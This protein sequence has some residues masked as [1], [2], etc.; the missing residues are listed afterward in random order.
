MKNKI[1]NIETFVDS[2]SFY[3]SANNNPETI[4]NNFVIRKH[5][6]EIIIQSLKAKKNKD[7]LQHEL[8]LGRRGA[9]KS[10]L[11]KRLEIEINEN[12]KNKYVA[13]NLAEEQAGIYQLSDLWYETLQELQNVLKI[14]IELKAFSSF[15]NNNEYTRY[16]FSILNKLLLKNNKKVVLLLDN[17]DRIL[18][19]LKD[20][21]N[22]FRE[23]LLNFNNIQIIGGS[24]RMDE[25]FWTYD[26]PFYE[27]FRTYKLEPLS[28]N[29]INELFNLWSKV[30]ELPLLK[31]YALKNR[32]KIESIRI[33]TD[34]LP[35]TLQFFIKILLSNEDTYG[36]EYI[37]KIMD[38]AT[39]L[40]QERLNNLT[41][42][43]RKIILEMAFLWRP[44]ATKELV[45]SCRMEAKLISAYLK[46]LAN[47]GLVEKLDTKTKNKKYRIIER[48]FNMWLIITQ[49][50]PEQKRRAKYLTIFLENWYDS[51]EIKGLANKHLDLL[52]R[53]EL[54]YDK[55]CVMT[56]ALSQSK[57]LD[58]STR[59]NLLEETGELYAL[60]SIK[61]NLPEKGIQILKKVIKLM[62]EK[63]YDL[64]LRKI[65]ELE[66]EED[67]VKFYYIGFIY[68]L[69]E[70]LN[71]AEEYFI[72]SVEKGNA[73]SMCNL[74]IL[75]EEQGK[76][77]LA[78]KYYLKG[79]QK[80]DSNSINNL[81][82]LYFSLNIKPKESMKL[83]LINEKKSNNYKTEFYSLFLCI[84]IWNSIFID[85][86]KKM[87]KILDDIDNR[88]I[89]TFFNTLLVLNQ[90][91]LVLKYF[92][93]KKYGKKLIEKYVLLYYT[94][95]LM[96]NKIKDI[97][98]T[99][100]SEL[101]PTINDMI[102]EIKEGK[103]FY[104]N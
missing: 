84:E 91:N 100:P 69:Q 24:T 54:S 93:S 1:K 89:L 66:S 25:H 8:I 22:L 55:A 29:E 20:D 45:D 68:N 85:I 96:D 71:D 13:I 16:L 60:D 26:K 58:I 75:Y 70:E 10:T 76:I 19:N 102:K 65:E 80:Q 4:K 47:F 40:Y 17:F 32:G 63:K 18:E 3:Q 42:P 62:T 46:Q 95:R 31:D 15:E 77:D 14:E 88:I 34:G 30:M 59:D 78:E 92:E 79:V 83:M 5:E 94:A 49:G 33:L 6:F 82:V 11:L 21:G 53:K 101:I 52:K 37:K 99:I 12:L 73:M 67:G 74:G 28:F 48:F 56:K 87:E 61:N 90:T 41:A 51:K 43:Q 2:L 98:L 44:S 50:N 23:L 72:K 103:E 64:A 36:F 104:S 27:F 9:G 7:S 86:D 81:A 97:N 57:Y 35:R 38:Q 39:P